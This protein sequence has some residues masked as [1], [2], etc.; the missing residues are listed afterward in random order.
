MMR[1]I[2]NCFLSVFLQNK[3]EHFML[4]WSVYH[5]Y[6]SVNSRFFPFNRNLMDY[7]ISRRITQSHMLLLALLVYNPSGIPDVFTDLPKNRTVC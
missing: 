4:Y 2:L 6:T 1:S 7:Q 3:C 5:K